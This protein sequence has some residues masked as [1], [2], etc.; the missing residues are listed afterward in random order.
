MGNHCV[1]CPH[2]G[3]DTRAGACDGRSCPEAKA[4][5]VA[6][7]SASTPTVGWT[8]TPGMQWRVFWLY[9]A[10]VHMRDGAVTGWSVTVGE[11]DR[12]GGLSLCTT[13]AVGLDVASAREAAVA[14]IRKMHGDLGAALA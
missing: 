1:D 3:E 10:R 4:A 9:R 8:C 11:G 13:G 5:A 6:K 2:C 7:A 14:C 12:G